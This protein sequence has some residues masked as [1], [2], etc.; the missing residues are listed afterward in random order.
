MHT[1]ICTYII[2]VYLCDMLCM[3]LC[4]YIYIYACVRKYDFAFTAGTTPTTPSHA[5]CSCYSIASL[6]LLSGLRRAQYL[7]PS[8]AL[9]R[10]SKHLFIQLFWAIWVR[11]K[12]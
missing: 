6:L 11:M 12:S 9:E 3:C 1:Y 10:L 5:S 7:K 2:R 8:S 4:V